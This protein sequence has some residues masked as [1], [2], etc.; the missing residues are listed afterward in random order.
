VLTIELQFVSSPRIV[1][2]SLNHAIVV[3][4]LK[5]LLLTVLR[6]GFVPT[7][8]VEEKFTEAGKRKSESILVQKR[9]ASSSFDR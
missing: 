6:E 1:G 9:N 2:E 3:E 5:V 7:I 8:Y 4:I